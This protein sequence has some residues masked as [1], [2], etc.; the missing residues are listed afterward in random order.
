MKIYVLYNDNYRKLRL[1][2]LVITKETNKRYY[3][4]PNSS[5]SG[6]K[7]YID[8]THRFIF[9]ERAEA[10]KKLKGIQSDI[11]NTKIQEIKKLIRENEA[12][13]S[14]LKSLGVDPNIEVM[15]VSLDLLGDLSKEDVIT[16]N[17]IVISE[18]KIQWP[19]I[20]EDVDQWA[21]HPFMISLIYGSALVKN[22]S[23]A[24]AD[25]VIIIEK[26][27]SKLTSGDTEKQYLTILPALNDDIYLMIYNSGGV[28]VHLEDEKEPSEYA[29]FSNIISCYNFAKNLQEYYN[30]GKL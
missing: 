2:T 6:Y 10:L 13:D 17:N 30:G 26:I 24:C 25:N 29:C 15:N 23:W 16:A 1:A 20:W 5:Y 9:T 11:I 22:I 7:T 14:Q 21:K 28:L 19:E 12:I 8:K 18:D 27:E 4:T 3:F